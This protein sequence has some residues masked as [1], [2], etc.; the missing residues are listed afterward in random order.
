MTPCK[1][2][3]QIIWQAGGGIEGGEKLS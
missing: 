1:L 2:V 3:V